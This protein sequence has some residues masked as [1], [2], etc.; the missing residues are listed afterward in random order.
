MLSSRNRNNLSF[1]SN[2]S[3]NSSKL[4]DKS[5]FSDNNN[6]SMNQSSKD[7]IKSMFMQS[8]GTAGKNIISKSTDFTEGY[9][10][11]VSSEHIKNNNGNNLDKSK[12]LMNDAN[13]DN[14]LKLKSK[15]SSEYNSNKSMDDEEKSVN[16][17]ESSKNSQNKLN[18]LI[19]NRIKS[20]SFMD[21]SI[22]NMNTSF[23]IKDSRKNL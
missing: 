13:K 19:S 11:T 6:F 17:S 5:F 20:N 16:L 14:L 7:G 10:Y 3:R 23:K 4:A 15:F 9:N 21:G 8:F 22:G 2:G 12:N 18:K 1:V